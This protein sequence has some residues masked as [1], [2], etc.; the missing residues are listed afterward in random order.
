[1]ANDKRMIRVQR[2]TRTGKVLTQVIHEEKWARGRQK[3]NLRGNSWERFGWVKV[4]D[5]PAPAPK[6]VK[7]EPKPETV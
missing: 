4:A 5:K 3:N 2:T 1:M 7:T 6:D